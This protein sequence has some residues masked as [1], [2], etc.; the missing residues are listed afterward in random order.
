MLAGQWKI[1]R[2]NSGTELKTLKPAILSLSKDFITVFFCPV[3]YKDTH[4]ERIGSKSAFPL[5][6]TDSSTVLVVLLAGT[7]LCPASL[8]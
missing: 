3:W 7:V 8:A 6:E 5:W 2:R 1:C 4:A